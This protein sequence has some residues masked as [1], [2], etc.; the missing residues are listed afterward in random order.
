M[1]DP[2]KKITEEEIEEVKELDDDEEFD[3]ISKNKK[4]SS[5]LIT[6]AIS[7]ALIVFNLLF[8]YLSY[9]DMASCQ[10]SSCYGNIGSGFVISILVMSLPIILGIIW[11][12]NFIIVIKKKELNVIDIVMLA[13]GIL[14]IVLHSAIAMGITTAFQRY[15]G[16]S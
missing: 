12:I 9:K 2:A 13:M 11:I 15:F 7:I 1:D 6:M 14:F 10:S 8:I 4:S 16:I 3:I 5:R